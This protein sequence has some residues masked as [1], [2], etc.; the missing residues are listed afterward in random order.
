MSAR[1]S[2]QQMMRRHGKKIRF[3]MV[4]NQRQEMQCQK[5]ERTQRHI[6]GLQHQQ[7]AKEKERAKEKAEKK[8]AASPK[9]ERAAAPGALQQK[10]SGHGVKKS[11]PRRGMAR[12]KTK[13]KIR[14]RAKKAGEKRA[15]AAAAAGLARAR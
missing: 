14:A 10:K 13:E 9:V 7:K 3:G 5:R 12:A 15:A 4:R 8:R 2:S 11:P 1:K 6:I